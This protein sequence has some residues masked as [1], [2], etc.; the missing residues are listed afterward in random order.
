M[1]RDVDDL[2]FRFVDLLLLLL[3]CFFVVLLSAVKLPMLVGGPFTST[4][5]A[6]LGCDSTARTSLPAVVSTEVP[7]TVIAIRMVVNQSRRL[8]DVDFAM[9]STKALS[10]VITVIADACICSFTATS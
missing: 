10:L 8:Q 2:N 4:L 6:G 9:W 1:F 7:M 5:M 3:L